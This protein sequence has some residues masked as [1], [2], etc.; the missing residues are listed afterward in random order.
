MKKN[1]ALGMTLLALTL[2]GQAAVADDKL[3]LVCS[4]EQPWC[5]LMAAGFE[6]QT[7]I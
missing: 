1:T 4:A 3:N 7:G 5:D 6:E 2:S